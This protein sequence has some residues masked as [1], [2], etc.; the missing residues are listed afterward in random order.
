MEQKYFL[1]RSREELNAS[2]GAASSEARF[3]HLDLAK[4]YRVKA[5]EAASDARMGRIYGTCD[6]SRLKFVV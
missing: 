1:A 5:A 4:R 2:T 6:D 3:V